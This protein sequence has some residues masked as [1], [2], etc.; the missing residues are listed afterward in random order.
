MAMVCPQCNRAY[1]QL[2]QCPDCGNRLL[3]QVKTPRP[4]LDE[5]PAGDLSQWQQTPWGRLAIGRGSPCLSTRL[6]WSS[7]RALSQTVTERRCKSR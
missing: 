3:Y 4:A 7:G 6:K 1:E 5:N 2:L